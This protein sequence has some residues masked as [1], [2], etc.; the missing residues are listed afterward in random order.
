MQGIGFMPVTPGT[1][2]CSHLSTQPHSQ[3][4]GQDEG[5]KEFSRTVPKRMVLLHI[6][7]VQSCL[8]TLLCSQEHFF[9]LKR[10]LSNSWAAM[11][12]QTKQQERKHYRKSEQPQFQELAKLQPVSREKPRSSTHTEEIWVVL[13][14]NIPTTKHLLS[15]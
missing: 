11:Q 10:K 7:P 1:A 8:E 3:G 5:A 2:T 14:R 9:Y 6:E 15:Q 13:S 4:W 12:V